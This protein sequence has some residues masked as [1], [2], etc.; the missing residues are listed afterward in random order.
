VHWTKIICSEDTLVLLGKYHIYPKYNNLLV[1]QL[2]KGGDFQAH[3]FAGYGSD[4]HGGNA[5]SELLV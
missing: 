4:S 1:M 2:I 3:R 5:G